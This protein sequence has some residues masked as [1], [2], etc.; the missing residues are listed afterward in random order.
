MD[1]LEILEMDREMVCG[2]E[3]TGLCVMS[4]LLLFSSY[5]GLDFL[6]GGEEEGG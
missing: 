3:G 5:N 1:E 4:S 2:G 6:N